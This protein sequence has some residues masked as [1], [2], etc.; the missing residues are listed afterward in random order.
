MPRPTRRCAGS[1]MRSTSSN[2]AVPVA[3][4]A[5]IS[6]RSNVV[7]PAP[8]R[9]MRPHISPVATARLAP[10]MIG[11]DPIATSRPET[12]STGPSLL[13]PTADQGLDASVGERRRRRP[14]GDDG[15]VVEGEHPVGIALD[16]LHVVL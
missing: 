9:P 14:V 1:A 12:L 3:A 4:V 8:L 16:D 6:A 15:A 13:A 10:W 2:V 5:P 11:I 7:F